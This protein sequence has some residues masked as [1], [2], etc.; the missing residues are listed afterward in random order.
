MSNVNLC[1]GMAKK[2]PFN[3]ILVG[4]VPN[5]AGIGEDYPPNG[6]NGMGTS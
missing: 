2:N 5:E 1:V 3:P 4:A 6:V